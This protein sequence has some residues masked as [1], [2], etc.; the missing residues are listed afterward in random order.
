MNAI[1]VQNVT[2]RY[3]SVV[4]VRDISFTVEQGDFFG[5]IGPNGAGK[6][7][8]IKSMLNLLQI[9]AG[10][11]ELL[12]A[13]VT[14]NQFQSRIGYIPGEANL[15]DNLT[16]KEQI[17]YFSRFYPTIDASYLEHLKTVF[18][19]DDSKKIADLSLGNK[20]KV[21]IVCALMNKPELLIAD[22]ASNSLDP[23]MQKTLFTELNELTRQG[24]TIFFSSHNLEEVQHYCR[25]VAIIK[26]GK[27]VAV[28]NIRQ[29]IEQVG[30]RVTLKTAADLEGYMKKQKIRS[31]Q[32]ADGAIQFMYT[33][34]VDALMKE[35]ARHAISFLRIDDITLEEIFEEHYKK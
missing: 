33:G 21:A 23:L 10:V 35:L 28:D 2:K 19:V 20:K 26:E 4:A 6:T 25:N 9:D 5:F 22:E 1:V 30:V 18:G 17:S 32:L 12:G 14:H 34:S 24:T 29:V 13:N 16:V 7:T 31:K 11:I 8:T 27:I 3:G 15:Y